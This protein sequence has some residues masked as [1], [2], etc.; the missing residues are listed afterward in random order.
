MT[1][2]LWHECEKLFGLTGHALSKTF[3]PHMCFGLIFCDLVILGD[4][5]VL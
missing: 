5:F 4:Y 3:F 1:Q 2:C